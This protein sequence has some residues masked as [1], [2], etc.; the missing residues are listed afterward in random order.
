MLQK[1]LAHP[2]IAFKKWIDA[3][4]RS[5][6]ARGGSIIKPFAR[7]RAAGTSDTCV[8]RPLTRS[9]VRRCGI[10]HGLKNPAY[11]DQDP[12]W[13]A[14]AAIDEA[15]RNLVAVGGNIAHTAILDNFCWGDPK[16]ETELA[17]LVRACQA[18]Y[19]LSKGFGVP[20]ISSRG[21]V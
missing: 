12:Y 4:A 11:G 1:L 18:C 5:R 21:R 7:V 8:V 14:A 17:A 20:F 10:E 2:N 19:D 6:S 3:A 13:M 9:A 15:L 16:D